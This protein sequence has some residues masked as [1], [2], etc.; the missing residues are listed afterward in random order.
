MA[1]K[2]ILI[3]RDW[4]VYFKEHAGK[5]PVDLSMELLKKAFERVKN[6]NRRIE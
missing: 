3:V 4:S 2:D 5:E 1:E 6:R